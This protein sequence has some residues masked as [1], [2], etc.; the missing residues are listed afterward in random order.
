MCKF[1][2]TNKY[3][4]NP[5]VKILIKEIEKYFNLEEDF[6]TNMYC[7]ENIFKFKNLIY[8]KGPNINSNENLI[9]FSKFRR[10]LI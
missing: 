9:F 6:L 4:K 7:F 5:D 2:N 8:T 1:K 10:F 3:L